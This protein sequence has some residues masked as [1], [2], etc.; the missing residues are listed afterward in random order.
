MVSSTSFVI[1]LLRA[2][3]YN[4]LLHKRVTIFLQLHVHVTF[5]AERLK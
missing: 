2:S 1:L 3:D 5:P 4:R